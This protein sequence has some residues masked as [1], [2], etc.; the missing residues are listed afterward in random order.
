[1]T[2]PIKN[3]LSMQVYGDIKLQEKLLKIMADACDTE[4]AVKAEKDYETKYGRSG[5]YMN[6]KLKLSDK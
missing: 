3:E 6:I 5:H 4:V 2:Q 1:M